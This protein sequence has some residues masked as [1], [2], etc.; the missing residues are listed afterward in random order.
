MSYKE[1]TM[2]PF[3]ARK[4]LR[5]K[6]VLAALVAC[7]SLGAGA[8]TTNLADAPLF[9]SV[10]VPANVILD[11]SVEFPTAVTDSYFSTTTYST[12]KE[13]VGYFNPNFCY[14]YVANSGTNAQTALFEALVGYFKPFGAASSHSC[15]GHWSGNYLNWVN[16]QTIDPLRKTLTGGARIVD[17]TAVVLQKAYQDNQGGGSNQKQKHISGTTVTGATP[18]GWTDVYSYNGNTGLNFTFSPVNVSDTTGTAYDGSNGATLASGS[19]LVCSST[20]T[21]TGTGNTVGNTTSGLK[22][23]L[24]GSGSVLNIPQGCTG[25]IIVSVATG[26]G[27]TVDFS[28]A[29]TNQPSVTGLPSGATATSFTSTSNV[30]NGSTTTLKIT[31]SSTAAVANNQ[32]ISINANKH[33]TTDTANKV[34]LPFTLNITTTAYSAQSAM[35]VCTASELTGTA[36]DLEGNSYT[37]TAADGSSITVNGRCRQY[38]SVYKPIGLMQEYAAESTAQNDSIRYAAFGYLLD[39]A[40]TGANENLDGGVL[41]AKMKSVGPYKANPGQT[42]VTNTANEWNGGTGIFVTNPDAADATA[43]PNVTNGGTAASTNGVLRSGVANYLNL[44]G[45][46]PTTSYTATTRAAY[47]R[48]DSVGELFYMATRYYRHLGNLTSHTSGAAA[49]TSG[50]ATND[51]FPVIETWDDPIAYTCSTNFIVGIGDI[52]TWDDENLPTGN[53]TATVKSSQEVSAYAPTD[54]AAVSARDATNYV[55]KLENLAGDTGGPSCTAGTTTSKGSCNNYIA[56]TGLGDALIGSIA[57]PSGGWGA[58]QNSFYMAGL[59]FDAHV[60]DI[61]PDITLKTAPITVSTFWLDVMEA[62]DYEQKNQFWLTAK[63][64]GFNTA[65]AYGSSAPFPINPTSTSQVNSNNSGAATGAVG[66][67]NT[68]T[69]STPTITFPAGSGTATATAALQL[70]S[71]SSGGTDDHGNY[72]PDQYYQAASPAKMASGLDS[73]FK[74]ITSAIPAGV[75]NA[76]SLDSSSVASTGSINYIAKYNNDWSGSLVAQSL[77][78]TASGPSVT[79]GSGTT[80]AWSA[81]TWLPPSA[82]TGALTFATRIIA[83]SSAPGAGNGV[84]FRIGTGGITLTQQATLGSTSNIQTDVL[85]YV[86]GDTCNQPAAGT[87][88]ATGCTTTT[89]TK[90][91]G[92]RPRATVLG[93]ITN[94]KPTVVSSPSLP[95]A[96]TP[97]NPGYSDFKTTHASRPATL[98]IGANDG[99][100]HAFDATTGTTGGKELFAYI[101]SALMTNNKD[102]NGSRVGLDSLTFNPLNHHFMVDAQPV[103]I[104]IDFARVNS[105]W[106]V[107]PSGYTPDWHTVVISGLGKGGGASASV[108]GGGYVALD[109]TDPTAITSE[110]ALKGKV[111]WE[112]SPTAMTHMGYSYGTPLVIKTKKYGWTLVLTSGYNND[113]GKGYFYLVNPKDG[114]LYE[115]IPT[116]AGSTAAPAGL[117]QVTA[118]ILNQADFTADALYAGDLLGNVW[119]VDLTTTGSLSAT[120]FATLTDTSNAGQ[121]VTTR[122]V[123]GFDPTKGTRYIFVGT[124]RLLADTDLVN[125]QTQTFYALVDGDSTAF[126]ST[127]TLPFTRSD[128]AANNPSTGVTLTASQKGYYYDLAAAISLGAGTQAS[129][130]RINVQP[131]ASGGDSAFAANLYGQ[132]VCLKGSSH[133]FAFNYDSG[134]GALGKTVIQDSSGVA[135]PYLANSTS[136]VT[137]LALVSTAPPLGTSSTPSGIMLMVGVDTTAVGSKQTATSS[138]FGDVLSHGGWNMTR[139]NWRE[140]PDAQ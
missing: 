92:F 41:R 110:S 101:P 44:F 42:V 43:T 122:P 6:L 102:A 134:V 20:N 109:V 121:P 84:A 40:G 133:V 136:V 28:T 17:D 18:L 116:G 21:A 10:V 61:R 39:A 74:A 51:H 73:A 34:T 99:M 11:L 66:A 27:A 93:D 16:T 126:D 12:A 81:A 7:T 37:T 63:Y 77:V 29:N 48:F 95:Y 112:T 35:Q 2:N 9:S 75:S 50:E 4:T 103:V 82:T 71:W 54:D 87:T 31:V 3:S 104:D 58:S 130:E 90:S 107:P 98:Y 124:G 106:V 57:S 24:T 113:D 14:D 105:T 64:G 86:R 88:K 53:G 83:T 32:T 79:L 132:N 78:L 128:L 65:I 69:Y 26:G 129:A 19:T 111:L 117:T 72:I 100:L 138:V 8:A 96:D 114:S 13:F 80:D 108:V 49:I 115:S 38:G 60:R 68:Y 45:F 25:T 89:G 1:S 23:Q 36:S 131:V 118:S 137:N 67:A 70:A 47:K 5:H 62:N 139:L 55:A 33:S 123:V 76:L 120:Q 59:A 125:A 46:V 94:S 140:V 56:A 135:Q 52:H 91:L 15:S 127:S 97:L 22:I 85:N 119:R 30:G